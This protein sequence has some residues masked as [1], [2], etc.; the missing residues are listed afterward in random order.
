M[1][2]QNYQ[3]RITVNDHEKE[4]IE[5]L[6]KLRYLTVPQYIKLAALGVKV[7]QV[8]EVFI[9]NES[10]LYPEQEEKLMVSDEVFTLSEEDKAVL[11]SILE[12]NT[13]DG[14]IRYDVEFNT[15]LAS[16]AKRL[17]GN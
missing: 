1:K 13:K 5:Q 4:R 6:A 14:Y 17:L 11:E 7:Q 2:N 9:K 3:L 12:R 8:K 15:Q 16:M 10:S